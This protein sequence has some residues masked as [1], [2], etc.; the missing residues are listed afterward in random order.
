[1]DY[2]KNMLLWGVVMV[3]VVAGMAAAAGEAGAGPVPI[4]FDTDMGND[5][6]DALALGLI[7]TLQTRG[8]C[9]LLAVTLSK[10]NTWAGPFVDMVNTFYGRGEIPVGVV[11]GGV[12]PEDG[13]YLRQTLETKAPGGQPAFTYDLK[14]G[15]DAP[16]AVTVLRQALAGQADQSVVMVQVGFSTN[17][18]RLL[19]S[20][21]DTASTLSGMDLVRHKV[22]LLSLM[23]G[24]FV[25]KDG[26]PGRE[27]NIIMDIPS[28][29]KLFEEWPGEIVASGFEIGEAILYPAQSISLDY[30]Y[31]PQHP[32]RVAYE[33]YMNFPYDR[34]TWDLT[35]VLYAV[36]PERKYFG[37]SPAGQI[38]VEPDSGVTRFI[39]KADGKHRYL[40]ADDQQ[41]RRVA[42]LFTHLC[43]Q[44]PSGFK[45]TDVAK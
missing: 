13:S 18:A 8:E 28:A 19:D 16:D 21:P 6:D 27:Y 10:D 7:H 30:R 5:I 29:K 40:R 17:L 4:I 12:T 35:S 39:E 34:P 3:L 14:K 1:M 23:G 31:V 9:R 11:R 26:K 44:P 41:C 33:S 32:L 2:L 36:R 15:E 42:E 43:S 24:A 38:I 22:R 37:L 25:E 20:K 45:G